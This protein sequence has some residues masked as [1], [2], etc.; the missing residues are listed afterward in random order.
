MSLIAT[1]A[2]VALFAVKR[3][4]FR[5]LTLVGTYSYEIY[6]LHWPW[7]SRYDVFYGTLPRQQRLRIW[8][9]SSQPAGR[10]SA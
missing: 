8:R 6:L 2:A 5:A 4:E 1:L 7:L 3:V 9:S 10:S